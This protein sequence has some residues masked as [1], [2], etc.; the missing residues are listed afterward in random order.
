MTQSVGSQFIFSSVFYLFQS[1]MN[2]WNRH[3]VIGFHIV[4]SLFNVGQVV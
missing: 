3:E 1:D 2:F 4:I